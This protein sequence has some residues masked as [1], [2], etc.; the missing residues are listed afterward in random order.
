MPSEKTLKM[1]PS[2]R[3]ERSLRRLKTLDRLVSLP[4]RSPEKQKKLEHA[5]NLQRIA[6]KAGRKALS[7][8]RLSGDAR[9]SI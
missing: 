2:Q 9:R 1:S 4:G 8:A 7:A 6:V 3:L 5:R